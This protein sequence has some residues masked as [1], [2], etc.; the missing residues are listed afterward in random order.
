MLGIVGYLW[1]WE[2][3][4]VWALSIGNLEEEYEFAFKKSFTDLY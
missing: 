4:D 3:E 2:R 1:K